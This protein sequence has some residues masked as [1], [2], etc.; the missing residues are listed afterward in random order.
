MSLSI[1]SE[2]V[3][4]VVGTCCLPQPKRAAGTLGLATTARIAHISR[5]LWPRLRRLGRSRWLARGDSQRGRDGACLADP[6]FDIQSDKVKRRTGNQG[7][8]YPVQRASRGGVRG[9]F[10]PRRTSCRVGGRDGKIFIWDWQ[11]ALQ[12]SALQGNRSEEVILTAEGDQVTVFQFDSLEAALK[13]DVRDPTIDQPIVEIGLRV[14]PGHSAEVRSLAF[15]NRFRGRDGTFLASSGHDNTVKV[16]DLSH[17]ALQDSAEP[18]VTF[19]GHGGWVRSAVFLRDDASNDL[20][21]ASGGHDRQVKIWDSKTYKEVRVIRGQN[22]AIADSSL[23]ADGRRAITAGR[24][25]IA[26]V[27]DVASGQR[28]LTLQE[29]VPDWA[30]DEPSE[31]PV[32]KLDEG[33]EFLVSSAI[34]FPASDPR[35]LTSA[36]DGTVR[37]WN[38]ETGGQLRSFKS[39]GPN[40]AMTLSDDGCWLLTGGEGNEAKLWDVENSQ[41]EPEPLEGHRHEVTALAISPGGELEERMLFTGDA[42]GTCKIWQRDAQSERWKISMD[43]DGHLR[44]QPITAASFLPDARQLLTASQDYTVMRW[45]VPSGKLL[46]NLTLKHPGGVRAMDVSPD[47]RRA[48]TVCEDSGVTSGQPT[49]GGRY[50]LS[51]WDLENADLL[52][53]RSVAG[54]TLTSIALIRDNR[55]ALVVA[56]TGSGGQLYRWEFD[57]NRYQPLWDDQSR[58]GAM[59]AAAVSRELGSVVTVGG[60]HARLWQEQNGELAQSLSRHDSLNSA[61]FSPSGRLAVTA[62][63]KGAVKIWN[64]DERNADGHQV[65]WKIPAAHGEAGSTH[66]VHSAVFGP[67]PADGDRY[68]LTAGDD[69]TARLWRLGDGPPRLLSTLSGR[70]EAVRQAVFSRDGNQIATASADGTAQIWDASDPENVKMAQSILPEDTQ[71]SGFTCACFSPDG[72][73]LVIGGEDNTAQI[74]DLDN[75]QNEPLSLEGHAASITSVAFSLD[76]TR[77]VSGSNDGIA[78]VWDARKGNSV[79]SL[80]RHS[81]EVTVVEFGR[82]PRPAQGD[83][84]LTASNDGTAIV[85]LTAPFGQAE[86][87]EP[88]ANATTSESARRPD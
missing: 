46:I 52:G 9:G 21:V 25:G 30:R 55:S 65:V 70:T 66:A 67:R 69:G 40:A 12:E 26:Y 7:P 54:Q 82:S 76:G 84:I 1:T 77:V 6:A 16:W 47:G 78:R 3:F 14:L 85:W 45:D 20:L 72:K 43:L 44:N 2:G 19:R 59:W 10:R 31:T 13:Q 23:S 53:S 50:V 88:A 24:E 41:Q 49:D 48:V 63:S 60:N 37:L 64:V 80:D 73:R 38:Y 34:F 22:T 4:R 15:S 57:S 17:D 18:A 42:S 51:L 83:R 32:A 86:K 11:K 87:D 27:W 75:L 36:G 79:L 74:W 39:T 56:A 28:M 29:T 5:P 33:H 58:R 62:D 61:A 68:L 8:A 35:L 81:A 71:T